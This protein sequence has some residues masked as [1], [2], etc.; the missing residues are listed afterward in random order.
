MTTARPPRTG[1]RRVDLHS[2]TFFSDGQLSPEELIEHAI[3]RQ[4]V[5]LGVT[6]HDTVEAMPRA[7]AA[8]ATMSTACS[9]SSS[10]STGSA[11]SSILPASILE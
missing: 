5:A 7:L 1:G 6:D 3:G 9:T 8:K 4:V 10:N 2:H 11:F